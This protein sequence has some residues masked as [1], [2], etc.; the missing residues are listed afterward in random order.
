VDAIYQQTG[1]KLEES[2]F[3][4]PEIKAV[5]T[6]ECSVSLHPEV[7]AT[8]SVV[9]Q[10]DKSITVRATHISRGLH[11]ASRCNATASSRTV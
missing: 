3:V 5:G 7:N 4:V 6:Y 8:F 1:R 9:I 10:K 2:E 11:S